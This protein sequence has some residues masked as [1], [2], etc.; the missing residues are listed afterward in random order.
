MAASTLA[1]F[2]MVPASQGR[3]LRRMVA[4]SATPRGRPSVIS[5]APPSLPSA[6]TKPGR[7][8]A[9]AGGTLIQWSMGTPA[10]SQYF[11]AASPRRASPSSKPTSSKGASMPRCS[12]SN[13]TGGT[14]RGGTGAWLTTARWR[15]APTSV[16]TKDMTPTKT[17]ACAAPTPG[18]SPI[19]VTSTL[20]EDRKTTVSSS[21]TCGARGCPIFQSS[22]GPV[23]LCTWRSNPPGSACSV[24]T[25]SRPP[26]FS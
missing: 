16:S 11:Q 5:G 21:L 13:L 22:F 6:W 1:H 19:Y 9:R 14:L 17:T 7:T 15:T 12:R 23:A 4:P 26:S 3:R 8:E 10:G 24:P 20:P 25:S 2:P 18:S